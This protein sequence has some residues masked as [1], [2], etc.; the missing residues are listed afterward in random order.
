MDLVHPNLSQLR[1]LNFKTFKNM[2]QRSLNM[3]S[4]GLTLLQLTILVNRTL[5]AHLTLLLG[6]LV[7][8]YPSAFSP[9]FSSMTTLPPPPSSI[10]LWCALI[11]PQA[12]ARPESH[13]VAWARASTTGRPGTGK[14]FTPAGQRL[15]SSTWTHQA[16]QPGEPPGTTPGSTGRSHSESRQHEIS[17][18]D[19][20]T[21]KGSEN[22]DCCSN[23]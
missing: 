14:P 6:P 21:Q 23:L 12:S 17:R 19:Q 5:A 2:F 15:S 8:A 22:L 20:T 11:H 3:S 4:P 10:I 9:V 1:M 13:R 18:T 16:A 7:L